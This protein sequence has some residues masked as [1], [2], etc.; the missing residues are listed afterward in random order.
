MERLERELEEEENKRSS[1][2]ID[3][4]GDAKNMDREHFDFLVREG[5]SFAMH[6]MIIQDMW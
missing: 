4:R 2:F 3:A 5:Y 6:R 1:E